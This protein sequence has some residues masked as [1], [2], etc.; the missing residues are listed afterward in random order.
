MLVYLLPAFWPAVAIAQP[1]AGDAGRDSPEDGE[2]AHERE[3]RQLLDQGL[4]LWRNGQPGAW[5]VLKGIPRETRAGREAQERLEQADSHYGKGLDLLQQGADEQAR[6]EIDQGREVGPIDPHRYLEVAD[7]MRNRGRRDQAVRYYGRYLAFMNQAGEPTDPETLRDIMLYLPESQEDLPELRQ[8]EDRSWQVVLIAGAAL[9]GLGI[10]LFFAFLWRGRTL[11]ELVEESPELD[12]RL[13]YAVGCLRHEVLKHRLGAL[14]D[15]VGA[16]RA[17]KGLSAGQ[18]TYFKE[19]LFG[20]ES[21]GRIWSIYLDTFDRLSEH[22]LN[23]KRRDREFRRAG[24]AI[25]SLESLEARFEQPDAQ[26]ADRLDGLRTQISR[27]DHYLKSVADKLCRTRIDGQLLREAIFSVQGEPRAAEVRLDEIRFI[28]PPADVYVEV[29]R[30]DLLIVLRNLVRN[31]ILALGRQE[32]SR[33]AL[34]ME[35][36]LRTEP[37]GDESVMIKVLDTSPEP[38]T[39]D[40]IYGRRLDRGLGLVAA[41]VTRY[42]GSVLVE[43]GTEM[44]QKAV[45]VRFFRALGESE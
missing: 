4:R 35:V 18:L 45:V 39:R 27:F 9:V 14:G 1:D 38:V 44:W 12:L 20:G 7:V 13:A 8:P 21:L 22:R 16:L 30:T 36:E 6:F 29:F 28:E 31:A 33:R 26:L 34:G 24:Q 3:A 42:D 17:R 10:A 41:A 32:D 37:S 25:H 5:L 43:P 11:A 2:R 19:R 40:D 23:L 15:A